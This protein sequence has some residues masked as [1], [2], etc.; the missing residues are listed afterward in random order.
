VGTPF[1]DG[2]HILDISDLDITGKTYKPD[3]YMAPEVIQEIRAQRGQ[4]E[5]TSTIC[6]STLAVVVAVGAVVALIK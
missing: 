2:T 1:P 3:P 5:T 6:I 4:G